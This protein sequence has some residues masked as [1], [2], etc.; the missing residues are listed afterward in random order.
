MFTVILKDGRVID[1]TAVE[2]DVVALAAL[3]ADNQ[4]PEEP[5]ADEGDTE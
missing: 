1:A 5:E 3:I 4:P 2:N